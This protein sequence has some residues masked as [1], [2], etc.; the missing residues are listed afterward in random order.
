MTTIDAAAAEMLA[1]AK[2]GTTENGWT[3]VTREQD[4]HSR[5]HRNY[6]LVLKDTAER[7]WGLLYSVGATEEQENEMPWVGLS[8]DE[9]IDL[10]R[11]YP[12]TVTTTVY[13]TKPA[14]VTA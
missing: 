9:Q 7:F 10:I 2:D 3:K 12:H 11:L 6:T 14:E 1:F 13:K 5:W 4:E 8:D